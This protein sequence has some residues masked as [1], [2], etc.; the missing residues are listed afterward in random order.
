MAEARR[1]GTRHGNSGRL[2][3]KASILPSC[4]QLCSRN[5]GEDAAKAIQRLDR[6]QKSRCK[7][8]AF[9]YNLNPSVTE[10]EVFLSHLHQVVGTGQHGVDIHAGK[11]QEAL[12]TESRGL[13][14]G[15]VERLLGGAIRQ[16]LGQNQS[17]LHTK[18]HETNET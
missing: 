10:S 4:S 3:R 14:L 8:A 5:T 18:K 12:E 7:A 9:L 15:L 1:D 11:R 16:F 13:Q 6:A 2:P 17:H